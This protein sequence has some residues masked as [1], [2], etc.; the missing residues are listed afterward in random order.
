[1]TL[2][3]SKASSEKLSTFSATDEKACPPSDPPDGGLQAWLQVLA[4]H[5]IVFNTFGYIKSV[6]CYNFFT[7]MMIMKPIVVIKI[8]I[9]ISSL[10]HL[11]WQ[12]NHLE[13]K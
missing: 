7:Q 6:V 9:I 13:R 10:L 8:K 5:L 4:A 1:M 11:F 2:T 12:R 3:V